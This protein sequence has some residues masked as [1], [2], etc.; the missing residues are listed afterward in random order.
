MSLFDSISRTIKGLLNDAADSVQDPS[1]DARQIIR[2]LDASIGRA[3]NSLIEIEAQVSHQRSKLDVAAAKAKRYEDGA[4]RALQSG[5]EALAREAL[6]AQVTAEAER[7]ALSHELATLEPSLE[8]L[9]GQISE[10]R[11][12]RDEL[13][14]RSNILTAKNEIAQAKDTAATALGGIGGADLSA[15]F[16][17]LEE[18]IDLANARSDARLG[19]VDARSG[20]S[21]DDKLSALDR[22]PSIEDRLAALKQQIQPASNG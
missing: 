15:D 13:T 8:Q 19:S 7:D 17:K 4:R 6:G 1:R 12:R 16:T 18:K 5:D 10:M 14:S 9:R 11:R 21:L 3:E 20:R 22:G 2:E